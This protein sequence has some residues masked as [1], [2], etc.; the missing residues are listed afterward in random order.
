MPIKRSQG[1]AGGRGSRLKLIGNVGSEPTRLLSRPD[2]V[3]TRRE[4]QSARRDGE[5]ESETAARLQTQKQ[6]QSSYR[7]SQ[8]DEQTAERLDKQ[9]EYDSMLRVEET[10][11]QHAERLQERVELYANSLISKSALNLARS[12]SACK[13]TDNF[14]AVF[15]VG[16]MTFSCTFCDAKFWESEKLS[17]STRLFPKFPLCCGQAKVVLPSI[18][19]PP[20]L[21]AHLLTAGDTRG[22]AFRD[23]IR[24]YNSALAFAS[25]GV[26]LDKQLANA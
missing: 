26:N 14:S 7:E 3:L 25:L 6:I 24:A 20:D 21:L 23:I 1:F 2:C 16:S 8:T 18:A 11:E 4:L 15:S 17:T 12:Q 13:V 9:R 22:R 5:S 10:A 19:T